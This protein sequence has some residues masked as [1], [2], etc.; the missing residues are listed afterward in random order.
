MLNVGDEA[1]WIR[2]S[3]RLKSAEVIDAL[4]DPFFFRGIPGHIRSDNGL[5]FIAKAI[6]E[7]IGAVEAKTAYIMP[8]WSHSRLRNRNELR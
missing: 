5:K 6:Q 3:L 2:I 7:W 4:A 1:L 8:P